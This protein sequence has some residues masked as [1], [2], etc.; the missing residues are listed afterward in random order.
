MST[1]FC[2]KCKICKAGLASGF[3]DNTKK[4]INEPQNSQIYSSPGAKLS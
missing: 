3:A 4:E 1:V 2:K